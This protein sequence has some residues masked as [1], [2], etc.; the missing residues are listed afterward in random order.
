MTTRTK[1]TPTSR[2]QAFLDTVENPKYDREII[3]GLTPFFEDRAP[4]DMKGFYSAQEISELLEIR[5]T[6]RDVEQRMPVKMTRH[7]FEMAKSSSSLQRLIKASPD[8]TLNL[9][10]SEDPGFQMDYSPVEG[11]LHKYEMGLMYV[12]STCSAHCRFCYREELISRKDIERQDGT[13]AKKGLAQIQEVTD[14]I[15]AHNEVV[16]ASGGTHPESGREKLREILL[17]GGDPMVL[18]NS[19]IAAWLS[20][21]AEA[22]V[23][24]IRLGTKE[25]AF[26][27]K[28]FDDAFLSMLDRF[29]EAYPE[30]GFRLMVHFNHPD[31]FLAKDERGDYIENDNGTLMWNQDTRHAMDAVVSRGWINVE[32]QAPIIK[33]I[34][35]D[36]DDLRIMQRSLY[37]VGV[38][39]HYFFCGRDI[40]AYQAFNV[41]IETAWNI[42]NESQKGLSGVET[43]ARLSITHYKG[44]TEVAAVTS[45]PIPGVP[46]SQNGVLIFKILRNA[47]DAPDRGK[48]CIVGRNPD[49]IWFD[50][51]ADRVIFDEAGL[52]EYARVD[53]A[54]SEVPVS[55]GA[56]N[57]G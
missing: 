24:S 37:R 13:V 30:V 35:D 41:P 32:N 23:E 5:G 21:L 49:A 38:G 20:A 3:S 15:R 25:M 48:V 57:G 27:P 43:H 42:L 53:A 31:E 18:P 2:E 47:A 44:K 26:Y 9:A 19:K 46:L 54:R 10:G 6:D 50:D 51:Y 22:G 45:E 11:L 36:P 12:I 14:Y 16:A 34:S 28:R 40:V 1:Y 55:I 39:N 52:F 56:S 8:E 33:G 17:S 29:H 4:D 7:Y